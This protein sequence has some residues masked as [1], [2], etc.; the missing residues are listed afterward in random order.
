MNLEQAIGGQV[1]SAG[2]LWR[3]QLHLCWMKGVLYWGT[4]TAD[5]ALVVDHQTY[6]RIFKEE[7][8]KHGMEWK[9]WTE[10]MRPA[11]EAWDGQCTI[12]DALRSNFDFWKQVPGVVTSN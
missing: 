9:T 7:L 11:E 4:E 1:I 10:Y 8:A 12:E 5:E 6:H 3:A 2:V